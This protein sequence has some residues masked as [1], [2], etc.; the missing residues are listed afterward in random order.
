MNSNLIYICEQNAEADNANLITPRAQYRFFKNIY[1]ES[2]TKFPSVMKGDQKYE[3]ITNDKN[4]GS[5][6]FFVL[7]ILLPKIGGKNEVSF[8]KYFGYKLIKNITFKL[9]DKIIYKLDSMAILSNVL[10]NPRA[11]DILKLAGETDKFRE[12]KKGTKSFDILIPESNILV[13]IPTCF[14]AMYRFGSNVALIKGSDKLTIIV[15]FND[16]MNCLNYVNKLE[17]ENELKIKR[18]ELIA[19]VFNKQKREKD[20]IEHIDVNSFNIDDSNI[21]VPF[22]NFSKINWFFTY[23]NKDPIY[24]PSTF[25]DE[26]DFKFKF[27]KYIA[28]NTFLV[29]SKNPDSGD[30]IHNFYKPVIKNTIYLKEIDKKIRVYIDD[31]PESHQLYYNEDVLTFRNRSLNLKLNLSEKFKKVTGKYSQE[32]KKIKFTKIETNLTWEEMS[33]P[34]SVWTSPLNDSGVDNRLF[35]NDYTINDINIGGK[36][37]FGKISPVSFTKI[38]LGNRTISELENSVI[39]TNNI[40]SQDKWNKINK[41]EIIPQ[42]SNLI[43]QQITPIEKED[44]WGVRFDFTT[45]KVSEIFNTKIDVHILLSHVD[46]L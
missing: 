14:D 2:P 7:D 27:E 34:K 21:I 11:D 28:K 8:C 38:S 20:Y 30:V 46:L 40:S 12:I 10:A 35:K 22:K 1:K 25:K 23:E 17:F 29:L 44:I 41:L 45:T 13:Y 31:I 43:F 15:E 18:V 6:N 24:Y 32:Q 26:Y 33:I 16:I 37:L 19:S 9:D 3:I 42:Q 4:I 39:E 36:D 5:L